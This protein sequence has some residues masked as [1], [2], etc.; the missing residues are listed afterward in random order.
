MIYRINNDLERLGD[1]AVNIAESAAELHSSPVL[2]LVPELFTMKE[3]ALIMLQDAIIA[4][5]GEDFI[6]SRQV[7]DADNKVD[8]Y[9]RLIYKKIAS[10]I[11][12]NPSQTELY[13][14]ILRVAKNLERIGDLSTN[15][16]EDTIFLV[17]GK[18]IKHNVETK[19]DSI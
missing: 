5:T 8:D 16:A 10:L 2:K 6:L 14:H 4:F 12:E 9:N 13:L 18:V 15:I 19:E 7:C 1:Q 11:R 17:Q 3:A